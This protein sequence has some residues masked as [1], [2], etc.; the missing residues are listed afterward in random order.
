MHIHIYISN[1]IRA[2]IYICV[3]IYIYIYI[4]IYTC[5]YTDAIQHTMYD[6]PPKLSGPQAAGP[7]LQ[8]RALGLGPLDWYDG[9]VDGHPQ[10][11]G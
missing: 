7:S 5:T 4:Y 9:G 11:S 3:H 2:Y 1:G 8:A 6:H 10:P